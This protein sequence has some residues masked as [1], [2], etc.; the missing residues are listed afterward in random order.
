MSDSFQ[1]GDRPLPCSLTL[2]RQ[3]GRAS[4]G[5]LTRVLMEGKITFHQVAVSRVCYIGTQGA[6]DI[7]DR[8][9]RL[10]R[11]NRCT[12]FTAY[13]VNSAERQGR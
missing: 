3:N 7:L 1:P 6:G 13:H 8:K 12:G 5:R 11:F 2:I 10:V 9:L 4:R